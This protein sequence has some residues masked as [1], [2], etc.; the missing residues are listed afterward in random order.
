MSTIFLSSIRMYRMF[1][2]LQYIQLTVV[3]YLFLYSI[4]CL[5]HIDH[6]TEL[7][8][9]IFQKFVILYSIEEMMSKTGHHATLLHNAQVKSLFNFRF[10]LT[11]LNIEN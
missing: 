9:F 6:T 5:K 8:L 2:F 7:N 1:L 11:Q 4:V 3:L 10:S